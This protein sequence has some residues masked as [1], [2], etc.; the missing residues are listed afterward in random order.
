ML[1][2]LLCNISQQSHGSNQD[3]KKTS[4]AGKTVVTRVSISLLVVIYQPVLLEVMPPVWMNKRFKSRLYHRSQS[5]LM[6][7]A[8]RVVVDW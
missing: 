4:W 6:K 8:V 1:I 2:G 3:Q 5:S 7:C